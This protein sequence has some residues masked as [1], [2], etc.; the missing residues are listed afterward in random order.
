MVPLVERRSS[1]LIHRLFGDKM[2]WNSRKGSFSYTFELE[3]CYVSP[4]VFDFGPY[5]TTV[6][7]IIRRPEPF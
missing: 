5:S 4:R 7:Q 1:F 2:R 3:M 6:H